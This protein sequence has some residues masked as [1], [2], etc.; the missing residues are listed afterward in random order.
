MRKISTQNGHS[1][2]EVIVMQYR[3]DELFADCRFPNPILSKFERENDRYCH[4]PDITA[5]DAMLNDAGTDIS[6]E[7][8]PLSAGQTQADAPKTVEKKKDHPKKK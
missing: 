4:I 7:G 3:P 8:G 6:Y 5:E 1:M 2:R